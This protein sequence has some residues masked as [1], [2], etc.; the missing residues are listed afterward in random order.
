MIVIGQSVIHYFTDPVLRAPTIGS[1]LMCFAA[2]L[3]GVIVFLRKES[4]VGESLSHAAYPGVALGVLAAGT[5]GGD[6]PFSLSLGILLGAF[7]SA[8]LGLV[9]IA[10]MERRLKVKS[11]AAL[12]FVLSAFFAVGITIASRM[13]FSHS[14]L[15]RQIQVYLYGQA[16]TMTDVHILIYGLLSLATLFAV[17][18]LYKEILTI[19]MDRDFAKSLG[20]RVRWIDFL[21]FSLVVLAVVIGIRSV[22]VVLMS[23]MLI[24]PAVSARQFTNKLYQMFIIAGLSALFSGFM[25]NYLSFEITEILSARYP[26]DR[27]GLPTGPMI[28]MVAS[29]LSLL[30]LFFAPER[31][32]VLRWWRM[33]VFRN[34]CVRENLLKTLWRSGEGAVVS[35]K[36]LTR[37]Q[38]GSKLYL[39]S[40]IRKLIRSGWVERVDGDA[41]CL[42]TDGRHRGSRII[43]LHRL[44]EVYLADY[45][46][47]GAEKVHYSAEE[48]EHILTPELERELTK[49][50]RDPKRDPHEQPIPRDDTL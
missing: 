35:L 18:F 37:Y 47:V 3:I 32:L 36:D 5:W 12:C 45:M 33:A 1:M 40:M 28:V 24:A 27:I 34:Q 26:H 49:L 15:Y 41:F 7:S 44:W 13:Q 25:G 20:I 46:G 21:V 29:T 4:L 9:A 22:G 17:L 11:D 2:G 50:L 48:M 19:T 43:R 31:G 14:A 39:K 42:T 23:A 6:N 16:A 30:A 8:L 38:S 10:F